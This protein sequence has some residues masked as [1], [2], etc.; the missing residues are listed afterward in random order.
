MK[1]V[2]LKIISKL[3]FAA[4]ISAIA[5][6]RAFADPSYVLLYGGF[7][8]EGAAGKAFSRALSGIGKASDLKAYAVLSKNRDNEL[9]VRQLS[10]NEEKAGNIVKAVLLLANDRPNLQ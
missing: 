4:A 9:S 10:E 1:F 6:P 5:V 2:F 7:M 3:F 8:N